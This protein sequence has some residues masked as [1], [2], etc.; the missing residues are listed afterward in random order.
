[1]A[2]YRK[3]LYSLK[4]HSVN[5][6]YV[7][8]TLLAFGEVMGGS[9]TADLASKI[10]AS[11]GVEIAPHIENKF[12]YKQ[13]A[14][15]AAITERIFCWNFSKGEKAGPTAPKVNVVIYGFCFLLCG[16]QYFIGIILL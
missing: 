2:F 11:V 5:Y 7:Q 16:S 1:M 4:V 15:I 3:R 6:I 12:N 13:F 10:W 14:G 9:V 8:G